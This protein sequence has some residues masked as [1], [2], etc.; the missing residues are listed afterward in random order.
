[1]NKFLEYSGISFNSK[2]IETLNSLENSSS[3]VKESSPE[4]FSN[5]SRRKEMDSREK[6]P[7][8]LEE[9]LALKVK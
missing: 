8:E 2:K 3:E 5:Q 6:N 4:A 9:Q 7:S 1:M